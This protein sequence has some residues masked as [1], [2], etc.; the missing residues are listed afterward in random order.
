MAMPRVPLSAIGVSSTRSGQR[1]CRPR[2]VR[3]A[4]SNAPTSWPMTSTAPSRAISSV[5]A[6][7]TAST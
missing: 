3:K 4:P 2:V 7:L 1:A 5:S 6:R